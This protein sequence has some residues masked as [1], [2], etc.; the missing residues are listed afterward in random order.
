TETAKAILP[1]LHGKIK[2]IEGNHDYWL[3]DIDYIMGS[4]RIELLP[5]IS[6][7]RFNKTKIWMCHYPLRV[8]EGNFKGAIHVYGH[9]HGTIESDRLMRSMDM[10]VDVAGYWPWTVEEVWK[11][12]MKDPIKPEELRISGGLSYTDAKHKRRGKG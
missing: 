6:R 8:W 10:S 2:L 9:C 1:R 12:L 11:E 3:D 7:L 4:E 5:P